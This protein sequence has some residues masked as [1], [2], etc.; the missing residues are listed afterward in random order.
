[1]GRLGRALGGDRLEG[2]ADALLNDFLNTKKYGKSREMDYVFPDDKLTVDNVGEAITRLG[3]RTPTTL[4]Y[5][6]AGKIVGLTGGE[7]IRN[8]KGGINIDQVPSPRGADY[9]KYLSLIHI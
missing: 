9:V 8:K 5:D 6:N 7:V 1:M 3:A 2:A 4:Q